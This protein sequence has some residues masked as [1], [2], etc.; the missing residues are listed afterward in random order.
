MQEIVLCFIVFNFEMLDVLQNLLCIIHIVPAVKFHVIVSRYEFLA[1]E[2]AFLIVCAA[3]F[4][5]F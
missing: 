1:E 2:L 5:H 4:T 3:F